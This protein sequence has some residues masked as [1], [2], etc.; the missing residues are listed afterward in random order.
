M[1]THTKK[2]LRCKSEQKKPFVFGAAAKT[3]L[4]WG[5]KTLLR[6][7]LLRPATWRWVMVKLPELIEKAE[8]FIRD[9]I[10]FLI[11]LFS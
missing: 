5:V 6:T 4:I 8:F 11:D 2:Q 10:S 7:L 9:V 1:K 3:A